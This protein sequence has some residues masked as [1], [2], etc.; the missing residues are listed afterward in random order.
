[1]TFKLPPCFLLQ[2]NTY[3]YFWNINIQLLSIWKCIRVWTWSA[4]Q[5]WLGW[6][7]NEHNKV[8]ESYTVQNVVLQLFW[9]Y[10]KFSFKGFQNS[11]PKCIR[12]C[13]LF[14]SMVH[15]QVLTL[16]AGSAC[17]YLKQLSFFYSFWSV[18]QVI[19][20]SLTFSRICMQETMKAK[21]RRNLERQKEEEF[22]FSSVFFRAQW[23]ERR[24]AQNPGTE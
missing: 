3:Y 20:F 4:W 5:E 19:L 6:K 2:W 16:R 7:K 1:M 17:D 9:K 18:L 13:F 21:Q 10:W 8:L 22:L 23:S 24:F 12:I 11:N 14:R 15:R